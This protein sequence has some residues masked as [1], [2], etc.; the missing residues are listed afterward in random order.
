MSNELLTVEELAA[1]LKVPRSW[2]YDKTRRDALPIIRVG[3]YLRFDLDA[4]M[5]SFETRSG[6]RE[7]R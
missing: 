1:K 3:K 5:T 2:I 6:K 4:V 7:S